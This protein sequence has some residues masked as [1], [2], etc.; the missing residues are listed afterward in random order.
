M[1]TDAI[2]NAD[3]L[4]II[5]ENR[6]KEYG[7]YALRKF[8]NNRLYKALGLTFSFAAVLLAFSF[9]LKKDAP[10]LAY[11]DV[12]ICTFAPPADKIP[13]SEKPKEGAPQKTASPKIKSPT[14]I[15]TN[16]IK[17]TPDDKA[18]TIKD[19]DD[20]VQIGSEDTKGKA[21]VPILIEPK[22]PEGP[23]VKGEP[24]PAKPTVDKNMP[25]NF[26]EIMPL[27]PGGMDALRKFLERNLKNPQDWDEGQHVIVKIRF[28]V[29]YDGT[30][31][32]FETIQDGGAV[33]NEEVIRVLK[34][35]PQWIPGKT[36]GENVS[37]YYTIPVN[38][39][40]AE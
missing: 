37:V 33:F 30:L 40:S 27:Y 11:T 20:N 14:Q 15:F 5:F 17:I 25:G 3:L 26:A 4:D 10:K 24:E 23:E 7:A 22:L 12:V 2:L 29:G 6:N 31:K 18:S 39:Q 16:N 35:M 8:Y 9:L 28:I 34:K 36:K 32:G 1:K 38:F 19:L 21:G 13:K